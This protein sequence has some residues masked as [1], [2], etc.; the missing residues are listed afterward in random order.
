MRKCLNW[1]MPLKQT[2][3]E[4]VIREKFTCQL[5]LEYQGSEALD[6]EYLK[7]SNLQYFLKLLGERPEIL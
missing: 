2:W 1:K 5:S 3:R 6:A 7:N 4:P